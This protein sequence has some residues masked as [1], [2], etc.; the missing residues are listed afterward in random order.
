MTD[1]LFPIP[2]KYRKEL[3]HQGLAHIDME[4]TP[5]PGGKSGTLKPT[6]Y[7]HKAK[8]AVV[9]HYNTAL[10]HVGAPYIIEDDTFVVWFTKVLKNWKAMVGTTVEGWYFEVTFNG[11]TNEAYVD[12]YKKVDQFVL[13]LVPRQRD[14]SEQS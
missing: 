1:P 14:G 13:N 10:R 6:D 12:A 11:N 8:Q 2:E 5:D 4:Y 9:Y 7:Q 3:E